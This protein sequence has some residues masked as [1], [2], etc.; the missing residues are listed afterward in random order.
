VITSG[1]AVQVTELPGASAPAG[2]VTPASNGSL[3]LTPVK[4]TAPVFVTVNP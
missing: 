1:L 4:V 2:Q 3:T